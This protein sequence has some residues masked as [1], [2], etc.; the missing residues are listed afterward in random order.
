ML[1]HPRPGVDRIVRKGSKNIRHLR[2][3]W[4]YGTPRWVLAQTRQEACDRLET[5]VMRPSGT[6]ENKQTNKKTN[7]ILDQALQLYVLMQQVL[8]QSYNAQWYVYHDERMKMIF[9]FFCIFFP[10]TGHFDYIMRY[11]IKYFGKKIF[12]SFQNPILNCAAL[13]VPP[14]TSKVDALPIKKAN[15]R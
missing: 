9:A 5:T 8:L 2:D 15:F 7:N 11:D 3:A 1:K 14:N 4:L 10:K 13:R 12:F 6:R